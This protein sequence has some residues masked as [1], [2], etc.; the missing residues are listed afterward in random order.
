MTRAKK[1]MLFVGKFHGITK[2]D[3]LCHPK[4]KQ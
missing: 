3:Y 4:K 1:G 2:C